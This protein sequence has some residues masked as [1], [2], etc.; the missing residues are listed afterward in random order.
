MIATSSMSMLMD[1]ELRSDQIYLVSRDG[2]G[3]SSLYRLS[4]Q[5]NVR[6]SDVYS[7]KYLNGDY[8]MQL[9]QKSL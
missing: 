5:K 9:P 6:K 1:Q 3:R 7:R 4:D 2:M 8:A